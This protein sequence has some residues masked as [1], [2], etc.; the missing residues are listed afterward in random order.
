MRDEFF[1]DIGAQAKILRDKAQWDR[2]TEQQNIG[3]PEDAV[4]AM[5]PVASEYIQ[6][7][8]DMGY[9]AELTRLSDKLVVKLTWADSAEL[10]LR[11]GR[12]RMSDT[13]SYEASG[14][15]YHSYGTAIMPEMQYN[16]VGWSLDSYESALQAFI[17]SFTDSAIEHGGL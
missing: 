11:A 16:R 8:R 6:R 14:Q 10:F 15:S 12:L 17:K 5:A 7:L 2:E 3:F 13:V 1:N 4:N 9:R